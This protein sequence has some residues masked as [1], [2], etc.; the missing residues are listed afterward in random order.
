MIKKYTFIFLIIIIVISLTVY[1]LIELNISGDNNKN[2]VKSNYSYTV[3]N[4]I[5]ILDK[6][7]ESYVS[8]KKEPY[9]KKYYDSCFRLS[10]NYFHKNLDSAEII[11][12]RMLLQSRSE[13]SKYGMTLAYAE[14]TINN[15]EKGE[16]NNA[17]NC[18]EKGYLAYDGL[19]VPK[20][21][22]F[23]NLSEG[24][25]NYKAD[26]YYEACQAI[27]RAYKIYETLKDEHWMSKC[28]SLLSLQFYQLADYDNAIKYLRK[29]IKYE[30]KTKS[31]RSLC[32]DYQNMGMFMVYNSS[33]DSANIYLNRS[34]ALLKKVP[35]LMV[36]AAIYEI[37][38]EMF[39]NQ[40]KFDSAIYYLNKAKEIAFQ[41][42]D[43]FRFVSA[44]YDLGNIA[45]QKSDLNLAG[46]YYLQGVDFAKKYGLKDLTLEGY[47]E[48]STIAYRYGN[49]QKAYDYNNKYLELREKD[50]KDKNES[51]AKSL[52]IQE[53]YEKYRKKI[54]VE[55]QI[56]QSQ[57]KISR[58]FVLILCILLIVLILFI[59]YF[60]KWAKLRHKQIIMEK[61]N[62]NAQIGVKKKE[63]SVI[64]MEQTK[65]SEQINSFLKE[66][67]EK[68]ASLPED[69]QKNIY[70]L[71]NQLKNQQDKKIWEEFE[72]RFKNENEIYFNALKNVCPVLTPAEI[73]IC[74]LLRLNMSTK[75]I[76]TILFKSESSVE[77]DRAR[78]R[79]KLGI[80][81]Q[82]ISLTDHLL[83]IG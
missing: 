27:F 69:N 61:Q 59:I 42:K 35:S 38:G 19:C 21:Y 13:N 50:A 56:Q 32:A 23:L 82:N 40:K 67:N 29:V 30:E 63:L 46:L 36:L 18:L 17:Y 45:Q 81:N 66:L 65:D 70:K 49:L 55:Q 41:A 76:A 64:L 47:K 53:I 51:I 26:N 28:N 43:N 73:K 58:R 33:Y 78:I 11:L 37:K 75:D 31:Y 8:G 14:L 20:L 39:S 54:L 16:I 6:N 3:E 9:N 15:A 34:I 48:L 71:I 25:L 24:F 1:F 83:T 7:N 4:K 77:V 12:N 62:L 57:L 74:L 5:I 2:S 22:A 80:T 10:V 60:V 72:I 68:L 79:K 44:S 52:E